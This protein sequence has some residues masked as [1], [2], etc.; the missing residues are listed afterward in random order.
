MDAATAVFSRKGF[1]SSTIDMIAEAAGIGK[2]TVY[3]YFSSKE[4]IL[5]ELVFR[6]MEAQIEEAREALAARDPVDRLMGVLAAGRVFLRENADLVRVIVTQAIGVGRSPEFKK[7]MAEF[8]AEYT[9]LLIKAFEMGQKEGVFRKDLAPEVAGRIL[10][11]LRWGLTMELVGS[12]AVEVPEE[13]IYEVRRFVMDGI[14]E[15]AGS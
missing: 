3:L 8:T 5:R 11:G 6:A 7:R 4:E 9:R 12:Q 14:G 13:L 15:E 1:H 10:S 2:G